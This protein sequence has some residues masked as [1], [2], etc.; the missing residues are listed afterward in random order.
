MDFHNLVFWR[1]VIKV[2]N[3]LRTGD[4]ESTVLSKE[5]DCCKVTL[6][7]CMNNLVKDGFVT[8]KVSSKDK[9]IFVYSLN[10]DAFRA[11]CVERD[12]YSYV[13]ETVE[14]LSD[15][16]SDFVQFLKNKD[17]PTS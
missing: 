5:V 2:V 9:R 11:F 3:L 8:K 15:M 6:V 16:R 10:D 13:D 14:E 1:N 12:L 7:R 17:K 4:K